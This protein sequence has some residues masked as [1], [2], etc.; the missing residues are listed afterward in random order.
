[1]KTS[2]KPICCSCGA[3]LWITKVCSRRYVAICSKPCI[4]AVMCYGHTE[5][6][7]RENYTATM[8]ERL[9]RRKRRA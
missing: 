1:M 2:D 5:K 8:T 9:G 3:E 7:A 4:E 6:E